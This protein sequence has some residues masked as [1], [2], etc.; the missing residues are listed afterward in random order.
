MWEIWGQTAKPN[1][2]FP[3]GDS[4]Y[5]AAADLLHEYASE[6]VRAPLDR[7]LLGRALTAGALGPEMVFGFGTEAATDERYADLLTEV[8]FH[9]GWQATES[10]VLDLG[11]PFPAG[12]SRSSAPWVGASNPFA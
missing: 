8:S 5:A 3:Y 4:L 10:R 9:N 7:A 11:E 6:L 1:L 2:I 12:L